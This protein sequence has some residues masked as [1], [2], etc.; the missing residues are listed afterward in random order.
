M[1]IKYCPECGCKI[2][3]GAKFCP[4]CGYRLDSK[5]PCEKTESIKNVTPNKTTESDKKESLSNIEAS[6]DNLLQEKEKIKKA[7]QN[8]HIFLKQG[9]YDKAYELFESFLKSNPKDLDSFIGKIGCQ[10]KGY[11]ELYEGIEKDFERVQKLSSLDSLKKEYEPFICLYQKFLEKQKKEE[12]ARLEHERIIASPLPVTT[13]VIFGKKPSSGE[14]VSWRV[15]EDSNG[16]VRMCSC[17]P[18]AICSPLTYGSF[19]EKDMPN[20]QSTCEKILIKC[21][22]EENLSS[23]SKTLELGYFAIPKVTDVLFAFPTLFS[24]IYSGDHSPVLTSTLTEGASPNVMLVFD[25]GHISKKGRPNGWASLHMVVAVKKAFLIDKLKYKNVDSSDLPSLVRFGSYS[26]EPLLWV[27]LR[28]EG[29]FTY[30]IL[31]TGWQ[32]KLQKDP[33][34]P[35]RDDELR[36]TLNGDF[37]KSVFSEEERKRLAPVDEFGDLVSLLSAEDVDY[38]KEDLHKFMHAYLGDKTMLRTLE[39]VKEKVYNGRYNATQ[40]HLVY[41]SVDGY[42]NHVIDMNPFVHPII[43]VA[44]PDNKKFSIDTYRFE[45]GK[46]ERSKAIRRATQKEKRVE[47][48]EQRIKDA[49]CAFSY[50][51]DARTKTYVL[52]GLSEEYKQ[53]KD[54]VLVIP[55][56]KISLKENAFENATNIV[57][58]VFESDLKAIPNRCFKGCSNLKN[59]TWPKNL[60]SI[61]VGAFEKTNLETID[62]PDTVTCIHY[63]AFKDSKLTS[64][65][66]PPMLSKLGEAAL[67]VQGTLRSITGKSPHYFTYQNMLFSGSMTEKSIVK[68][69]FFRYKRSLKY[70][71]ATLERAPMVYGKRE[72]DLNDL[73]FFVED[74]ACNC[75]ENTKGLTFV[76]VTEQTRN[77]GSYAFAS[78]PQLARVDLSPMHEGTLRDHLFWNTPIGNRGNY[79]LALRSPKV[80]M[81]KDTLEKGMGY[82]YP[83]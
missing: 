34:L 77:I 17:V 71:M 56:E 38:F 66:V 57:E 22:G 62:L 78:C 10:S 53:K 23:L 8:A 11:Q 55:N 67:S 61:G 74:I 58:V 30:Y 39:K 76:R 5:T 13:E 69:P 59:I 3:K 51:Y 50:D 2:T 46:S 19:T 63:D 33:Q 60:E 35:W 28:A 16:I 4:E 83:F 72:Y 37:L 6:F 20:I 43:R 49:F 75:F 79:I 54:L 12:E 24:S 40:T 31:R 47:A 45:K 29:G 15:I 7:H 52:T 9:R 64:F 26:N 21:I 80:K 44:D 81:S 14:P 25:D 65:H 1:E 27:P 82:S 68:G 18:L 73:P 32:V 41:G 70:S 42:L 48:K 36:K